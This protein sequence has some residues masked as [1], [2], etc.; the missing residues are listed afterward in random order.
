MKQLQVR[1]G[2]PVEGQTEDETSLVSV[3]FWPTVPVFA[4]THNFRCFTA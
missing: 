4:L 2:G 1:L 3:D